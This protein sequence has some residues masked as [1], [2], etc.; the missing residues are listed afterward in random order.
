[1]ASL[2]QRLRDGSLIFFLLPGVYFLLYAF[3]G[4][5]D[6]DQGFVPGLAWRVANGQVP[7]LDFCY[8]RPPLTPYL[9]AL[10]LLVWPQQLEILGSRLD[11]YLMLWAS[12]YWGM[13]T[14]ERLQ[15]RLGGWPLGNSMW[16]LAGLAFV[17][18]VHNYP[19]MPWHTVDGIFFA[20]LGVWLV[21]HPR[22]AWRVVLGL[23]MLALAGLAKQP[24]ALMFPLGVVALFI[25]H[26][27]KS[28]LKIAAAAGAILLVLGACATLFLLPRGFLA[29]ML[30]QSAG[31]SSPAELLHVGV[32][33][34]LWPGG[35]L[36]VAGAAFLLG[37]NRWLTSSS[38]RSALPWIMLAGLAIYPLMMGFWALHKSLYVPPR[39]GVYHALWFCAVLQALFVWRSGDRKAAATLGLL[40][41]ISWVCSLSWGNPV[42]ALFVLPGLHALLAFL[43]PKAS[44]QDS[45]RRMRAAV[46]MLLVAAVGFFV[47]QLLPYR[48]GPR[49]QLVA[50]AGDIFPQLSF[51]RTSP[52]NIAKLQEYKT[53]RAQY[54]QAAVLPAMPAADYLSGLLP[55]LPIDW[56]HDAEVGPKQYAIV[57]QDMNAP[58][59][60]VLVETARLA[61]AHSPNLLYRS[62]LL[63]D[64]LEY[65]RP[66]AKGAYFQVYFA[67]MQASAP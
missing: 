29:A 38:L 44:P 19:A 8:V 17:F 9:H 49:L 18:G 27:S 62:S 14:L 56:E 11:F 52:E 67:P 3:H 20:S 66:G 59:M 35:A 54:P 45:L 6:T 23:G 28:A 2:S 53:L 42:P 60:V 39:F 26:P 30:A 15:G 51:I 47:L 21:M 57:L 37:G 33:D 50:G 61:E 13:R 64:V 46:A 41:A 31:A 5:A 4:F 48:D 36:F 7:Y 55:T 25:L 34:Y 12:V 22:A 10:E 65:W 1:M 63:A 16:W 32:I 40:A 24:F 43:F 58:G